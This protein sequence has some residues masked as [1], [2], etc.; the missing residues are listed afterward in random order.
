MDGAS[1]IE[2]ETEIEEDRTGDLKDLGLGLGLGLGG[3]ALLAGG[4][5][6]ERGANGWG[7]LAVS[8]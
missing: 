8:G 3:Q 6:A 4:R 1:E 5:V 7:L 2:A